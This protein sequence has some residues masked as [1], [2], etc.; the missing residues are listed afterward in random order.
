MGTTTCFGP[1]YWPSSG[2]ILTYRA[3][4]Q[5]V[6]GVFWGCGVCVRETR[7]R[8]YGSNTGYSSGM[9]SDY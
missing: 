3:T 8:Y 2:C 7:S 9:T 1:I 6:C 5:H 4:I